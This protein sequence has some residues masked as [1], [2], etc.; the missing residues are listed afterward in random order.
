MVEPYEKSTGFYSSSTAMSSLDD[1]WSTPR[2]YYAKVDAEFNFALDAAALQSSTLV[3][4]NWYGPD[5]PETDRRDAFTR[6]WTA[7]AQGGAIWLNPPYGKTI[8]DWMRKAD[9]ESQKGATVVCLV[10][11]RTD[12]AWFHDYAIHHEVRFIRGRLKFGNSTNSAPFP[13]ALVVMRP[14]NR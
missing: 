12:T 3:V 6:D 11:A 8:K 2:S 1:T 4:G 7:D 5:H 10:P 9:A 14:L 13:S